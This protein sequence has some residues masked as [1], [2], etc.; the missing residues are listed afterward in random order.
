MP[1][2]SSLLRSAA[3]SFTLLTIPFDF[4]K[5][6]PDGK[7]PITFS[8]V[9]LDFDNGKRYVEPEVKVSLTIDH[10]GIEKITGQDLHVYAY[11]NMLYINSPVAEDVQIY[12]MTG[13]L[14]Y[15]MKK[16]AGVVR[17]PVNGYKGKILIIKGSI[18]GN[19]K[20]MMN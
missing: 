1:M 3:Q 18:S 8:N 20:V 5:Q 11:D 10:T 17:I 2:R 4:D 15:Q 19:V 6:L 16:P 14:E 7:Y 9:D 13:M 12:T